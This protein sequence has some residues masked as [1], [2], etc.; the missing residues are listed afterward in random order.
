MEEQQRLDLKW[1]EIIIAVPMVLIIVAI[2][3]IAMPFFLANEEELRRIQEADRKWLEEKKQQ[4][5]GEQKS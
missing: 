2:A 1:W 4:K 3:Y 5:Q